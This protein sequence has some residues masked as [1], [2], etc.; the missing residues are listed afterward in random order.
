MSKVFLTLEQIESFHPCKAGWRKLLKALNK[1]QADDSPIPLEFIL[2]SI[3]IHDTIWCFRCNWFE[4]KELYMQFVNNCVSRISNAGV[5]NAAA[6]TKAYASNAAYAAIS[7]ANAA[8]A[9]AASAASANAAFAASASYYTS[10][11]YSTF[12]RADA[13]AAAAAERELQTQDLLQLLRS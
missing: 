5:A 1:V 4:H 7:A 6:V 11:S 9:N 2:E 12:S 8:N 3:E 13:E 10:A